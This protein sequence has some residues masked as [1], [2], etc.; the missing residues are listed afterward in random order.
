MKNFLSLIFV[1][2]LGGCVFGSGS[3]SSVFYNISPVKASGKIY[4]QPRFSVGIEKVSIPDYLNK[5]Q[6]ITK[7]KD[8]NELTISE[9]NRWGESL[10]GMLQR[11]IAVDVSSYLPNAVIKPKGYITEEFDYTVRVEIAAFGGTFGETANLA[12]WWMVYDK[13]E[14]LLNRKKTELSLPLEDGYNNLAMQQSLLTGELS[15]Q[16]AAFL[17]RLK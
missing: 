13:N 17:S 8:T 14:K 5:P 4:A 11:T 6:M 9:F 16:I 2:C 10:S 7:D 1:V 3:P 12:A 15:K